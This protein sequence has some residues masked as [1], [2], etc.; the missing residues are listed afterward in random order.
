MDFHRLRGPHADDNFLAG[1]RTEMSK[2]K[3][4]RRALV[5]RALADRSERALDR[6][7]GPGPFDHERG[8][9]TAARRRQADNDG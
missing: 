8:N 6:G 9:R 3:P 5:E 7:Q 1:L 4:S 2:S